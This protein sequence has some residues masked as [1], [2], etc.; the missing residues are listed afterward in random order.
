MRNATVVFLLLV[1]CA[2]PAISGGV[3]IKST[4]LSDNGDDDGFADSRETVTL[5][6]TVQNTSGVAL[7]GVTATLIARN[8][9]RT[10]LTT[11]TIAIGD[12][13]IDES[14]TTSDGFVFT[15]SD[16]DR[17]T[18]GLGPYDP[19]TAAFELSID[20][21]PAQPA[22]PSRIFLDLDLDVSGGSGPISV[23]ES[24][25][26]DTL[27]IFEVQNLDD[28]RATLPA[29]DGFRCQYNDPDFPNSNTFPFP[30]AAGR[31][32]LGA[33]PAHAT[34]TW[35][36]L[37]GPSFSPLG[38]RGFSGFH[39]MFFG[40]DLGPP[41]NW[42]TPTGIVEAAGLIDPVAIAADAIEPTLTFK[43]QVS[44][45]DSRAFA[46]NPRETYDR[47]VVM[48][49]VAD[50]LGLPAGPWVKLDPWLNPYDQQHSKRIL[51][52]AYDPADDG[53][54]E[55]DY[56]SPADPDRRL[57]PS[58]TCFPEWIYADQ[59]ETSQPFAAANVGLADGPGLQGLWGIGTWIEAR[60][61]LSQFRGR[62]IRVRFLASTTNTLDFET[63]EEIF[64]FNPNSGDDGWWID[65]VEVLGAID[66]PA[67][68]TVD[69]K[70]NSGL[71]GVSG[72][73]DSDSVADV[74]DN[75]PAFAN[76][77]QTDG[78]LDT[79]GDSCDPCPFDPNN[80]DPDLDTICGASDNCPDDSNLS[81][82]DADGDDAGDVCDCAP[83]DSNTYPGAQETNDGADNNCPG[84]PGFG[85]ADEL[86]GLRFESKTQ[87]V[88]DFQSFAGSYQVVRALETSFTAGCKTYNSNTAAV[89][90]NDPIL[91]TRLYHYLARALTPNA[92]SLGASSAGVERTAVCAP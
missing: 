52:C 33:N 81:Q 30:D 61:D 76:A 87:I 75:C 86:T 24:F 65:D 83:F 44:L 50:D 92:G 36:G 64:G 90:D 55:D 7:T 54:T 57:G 46:L 22:V 21:S 69:S 59:G 56:F 23:F 8:P 49:Q 27:G 82:A 60:F 13:A 40:V 32:H 67:T 43:H 42:T 58:S 16:V 26:D 19:L 1:G 79:L 11:A 38:G 35:W 25:E 29:S 47:G 89:S 10:C 63:W 73:A 17:A 70:D 48:A 34:A 3:A 84:D 68:V 78:D 28:G 6:L 91:P 5:R 80:E 18:L 12:L 88:F 15:V 71:P 39:S 77:D 74:C 66:T 9:D 62:Q 45:A 14:R 72:D 53:T 20:S 2:L 31:C 4:H 41:E 37:S 51:N 85:L